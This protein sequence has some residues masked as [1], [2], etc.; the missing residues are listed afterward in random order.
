MRAAGEV[1]SQLLQAMR[2]GGAAGGGGAAGAPPDGTASAETRRRCRQALCRGYF[3]NAAK[4]AYAT[5]A[6][7][8]GLTGR[9]PDSSAAHAS[10]P[11]LGPLTLT[12]APTL[13]P[14]PTLTQGAVV[15]PLWIMRAL[16]VTDG[17]ELLVQTI[18]LPRG[19][20]AKLQPLTDEFATSIADHKAALEA[21]LMHTYTTLSKGDSI[22]LKQDGQEI[23]M[24]VLEVQPA[25]AVC[26]VDTELE[27]DFAMNVSAESAEIQREIQQAQE[28]SLRVAAEQAASERQAAAEQ[29]AR[30]AAAAAEAACEAQEREA[31]ARREARGDA[32]AALP[33][34]PAAGEGVTTVLVRMPDGPRI[35]RRFDK[36]APLRLVR[37]W[38]EASSPAEMR[39]VAFELVS[40]YPRFVATEDNAEQ[41]LEQAG[42]HP[43]ATMFVKEPAEV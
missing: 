5:Q 37:R 17:T 40:T 16:G 41:T 3:M 30:E 23:E 43:Q 10:E 22:L 24:F 4:R 15:V 28:A 2:S 34:E 14:T 42:L 26:I 36:A 7:N 33:A 21:A 9:A 39:M 25:D 6:S 38:V 35:S 27:V 1:R 32:A 19:S 12:L 11:R 13:T 29:S 18:E 31:Q 20:F 8:P